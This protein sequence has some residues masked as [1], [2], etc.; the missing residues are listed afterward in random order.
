MSCF[1]MP[2][3]LTGDLNV[4]NIF[5]WGKTSGTK[6]VHWGRWMDLCTSK[7]HGGMG[8]KIFESFNDA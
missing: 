1:K 6:G 8:F 7:F 4:I 3:N 5:W 2:L